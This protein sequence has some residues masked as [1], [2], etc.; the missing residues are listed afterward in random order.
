MARRTFTVAAVEKI[1]PPK[2]G[3]VDH[4][5]GS[6]PGLSLRVSYGGRKTWT[7]HYRLDGRLH[8]LSLGTY[9]GLKTL[10]SSPGVGMSLVQAR[11]AWLKARQE[12]AAKRDPALVKE[13]EKA[14]DDF[15]TVAA[16]WLKRD[17]A[18]KRSLA[19]TKRILNRD[20]LPVWGQRPINEIKRLD[21]IKLLDTIIDRGA[22][23]MAAR[24]QSLVH[25]LF[26]W[27]EARSIIEINPAA[28]LD[29][30]AL[31]SRDRVLT[32]DELVSVWGAAEELGAPYGRALHLL[33]LTGARR[34]EI[35]QLK[36]TEIEG[37]TITLS[38]D[39]TKNGEA[40]DIPLSAAAQALIKSV[41]GIAGCKY[42]FTADG[43]QS[44]RGWSEAKVKID[45]L[46]EIEPWRVHDLRRTVA[47]GLQKMGVNL[48]VTE[49]VLGH[50]SGSRS[51]I[52]GVYQRH[53][54][55]DEKRA[56][57]E[58]WGARLM[59]LIE[60][61]RPSVVLPLHGRSGKLP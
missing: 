3:Q 29:R 52:V 21:V 23:P 39:R 49:A 43:S 27:A 59:G 14:T 34:T 47:T 2:T 10:E 22:T 36:W 18:G 56:A 40:H 7:Y 61:R 5:D 54:Y 45:K 58:A 41:A 8:R 50:T 11:D 51:G 15:A 19:E 42:V 37:T 24:V 12:V 16:E 4:F 31:V 17:Q 6:C 32:D 60:G 13:Q 26:R 53:N 30:P 1:R 46:A 44:I 20:L 33:A 48:Q 57:L 9:P 38:G 28:G 55:A 35:S 25:R